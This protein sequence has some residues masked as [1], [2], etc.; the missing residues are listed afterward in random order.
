M[1]HALTVPYSVFCIHEDRASWVDELRTT[2]YALAASIG[3]DAEIVTLT[4]TADF[5]PRAA[6]GVAVVVYFGSPAGK[7]SAACCDHLE[8]AC[9]SGFRV[10][11][12]V[13][14]KANFS[15]HI[16]LIAQRYNAMAWLGDGAVAAIGHAIMEWLGLEDTERRA[17]ISH[18]RSD[19][20][21]LAE[22]IHDELI[23]HRFDAFIDRFDIA[24]G[25][26]VQQ[27][28]HEALEDAA[29]VVLVESPDAVNST[30][31][32]E[33]IHYALRNSMGLLIV[34]LPDVQ[35]IPGT[36]GLPRFRLRDDIIDPRNR[37]L[38]DEGLEN[39]MTVIESTH[40]QMLV[41]R[42]QRMIGRALEVVKR[43]NRFQ[44]EELAGNLMRIHRESSADS[45]ETVEV[46]VGFAP[47]TPRPVDLYKTDVSRLSPPAP[48]AGIVL[49][50][51]SDL[52][53]P[54]TVQLLEWCI[55]RRDAVLLSDAAMDDLI[56]LANRS[57]I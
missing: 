5:D 44:A 39:L 14:D 50:H 55:D 57:G 30:W 32:L 37:T 40:A 31:V 41:H 43:D 46:I 48:D 12:I 6:D 24:P 23:K 8:R 54:N 25:V 10:L 52:L 18:R 2:L 27:R 11:P 4:A 33:E 56:I 9:N 28:I 13:D 42:R 16:P 17:F 22:Q 53:P 3:A 7:A 36:E 20:L 15:Q 51:S 49:V 47:R 35:P 26:V 38:Q 45:A 29:F 34:S 1:R 19:A 21:E